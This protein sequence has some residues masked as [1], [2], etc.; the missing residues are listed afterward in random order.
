MEA[1]NVR[2][3]PAEIVASGTVIAFNGSPVEIEFG[4]PWKLHLILRF[5]DVPGEEKQRIS[6]KII[7]RRT[8]EVTFFNFKNPLGS[9]STRAIPIGKVGDN[10]VYIQ[11]R[12]HALGESDKTLHYTIYRAP[13]KDGNNEKETKK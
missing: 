8:L 10:E 5:K 9:G 1:P 4:S 3:G 7:D 11:Y 2:S 6:G 12:I 13:K